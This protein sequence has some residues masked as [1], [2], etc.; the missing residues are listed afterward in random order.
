MQIS[1]MIHEIIGVC[2]CFSS[3][4]TVKY[5]LAYIL[6]CYWHQI[7]YILLQML[8]ESLEEIR[9]SWRNI[10]FNW[11]L[12]LFKPKNAFFTTDVTLFSIESEKYLK[13]G[14]VRHQSFVLIKT[15]PQALDVIFVF[16][17]LANEFFFLDKG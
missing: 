16:L 8:T 2:L 12:N 1:K 17:N 10:F 5:S 15:K 14:R 11:M 4:I 3:I 13:R 9:S 6:M 7:N